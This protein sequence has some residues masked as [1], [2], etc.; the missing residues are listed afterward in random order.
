VTI[1]RLARQFIGIDC[2]PAVEPGQAGVDPAVDRARVRV[3]IFGEVRL[4]AEPHL[5]IG[6]RGE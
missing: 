6:P 1:D 3:D 2:H 5:A 4:G